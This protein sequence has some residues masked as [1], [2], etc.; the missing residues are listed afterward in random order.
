M[1][2]TGEPIV[3]RGVVERAFDLDVDGRL[4]PGIVWT[5]EGADGPRPLVLIGH[6]ASLHKRIEYVVSL[7]RRFVRH[8]GFAAV[9]IDGPDH[10]DRGEITD[11][12]TFYKQTWQRPGVTDDTIAD[13]QAT[14]DA[15]RA[16]PE[17]GEGS[18]GYWGL[19]MG[20][21]F[22]LPF[23]AAEPRIEVAVFGL[24]GATGP[25]EERML[26]DA[27]RIACPVLF[28]Q[29]WD[30]ELFSRESVLRLFDAIGTQDKRLYV[31][32]GGHVGVPRDTYE[33]SEAFVASRLGAPR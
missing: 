12:L 20:A 3:S 30:D 32:P 19:S 9:A 28:L 27:A 18:M 10:G 15:V 17:V 33:A 16:L 13:W 22:G 8:H 4:V 29:Q 21:I 7:A 25:T 1:E 14:A 23:V 5:P 26:K 31:H 24:A 11:L 2:W 6:G